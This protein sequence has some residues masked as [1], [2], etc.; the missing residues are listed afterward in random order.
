M[1]DK[2]AIAEQ[3][4][5]FKSSESMDEIRDETIDLIKTEENCWKVVGLPFDISSF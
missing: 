1:V 5:Y 2:L 4:I 3:T